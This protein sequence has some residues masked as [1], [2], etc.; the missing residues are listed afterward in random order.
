VRIEIYFVSLDAADHAVAAL[1]KEF[2]ADRLAVSEHRDETAGLMQIEFV[3]PSG[4]LQKE[5]LSQLQLRAERV[6]GVVI[7]AFGPTPH[8]SVS[9]IAQRVGLDLQAVDEMVHGSNGHPPFPAPLNPNDGNRCGTARSP[10]LAAS[11]RHTRP[12]RHSRWRPGSHRTPDSRA[13]RTAAPNPGRTDLS[14]AD[15]KADRRRGLPS[16]VRAASNRWGQSAHSCRSVRA[17][18]RRVRAACSRE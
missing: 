12:A 6:S 13:Q 11:H 16:V 14:N 15:S 5:D 4:V 9:R 17:M 1:D 8:V 3:P 18:H 10:R 7:T 2:A